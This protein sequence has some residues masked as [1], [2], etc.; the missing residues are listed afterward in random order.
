M[1]EDDD[2]TLSSLDKSDLQTNIYEG[3]FKTWECSLD[4]AS[5]LLDRGP[6]KDIDELARVDNV[7][8]LGAGTAIP[9]LTL[10]QHALQNSYGITFT[11]A[12]YNSA[13]LRLVTLPNLLLTFARFNLGHAFIPPTDAGDLD[14]TPDL[15]EAFTMA[16]SQAGIMLNF[17]SGPWGPQL[18]SLISPSSAEMGTLVLAAE[19]IYSPSS[20]TAFVELM[21]QILRRT[22]MAKAIVAAKR[23]YFGV[24]GSVDGLKEACHEQGAVAHEVENAGVVGMDQGVGRALVEVQMY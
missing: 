23:V 9:T 10:F 24:G 17:R 6:R 21:T 7:I 3:G 5:L 18:L 2:A 19:T 1:A 20:T 4:L 13:V 22:R 15:I 14:I 12:D 11:L 8:E 16:L